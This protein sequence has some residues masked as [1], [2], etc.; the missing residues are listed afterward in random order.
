[1]YY[2]HQK[3]GR[4]GLISF[5]DVGELEPGKHKLTVYSLFEGKE[6]TFGSLYFFKE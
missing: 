5:L 4:K 1:M 2:F 3:D 6:V